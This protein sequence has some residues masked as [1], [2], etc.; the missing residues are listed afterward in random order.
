MS[1]HQAI[2]QA[3]AASVFEPI[4]EIA[5]QNGFTVNRSDTRMVDDAPL[6]LVVLEQRG[7]QTTVAFD[8][9]SKAELQMLKELYA[10]R[11]AKLGFAD[12]IIW[13][14]PKAAAPLNQ[15]V[16]EIS[17]CTQI[18]PNFARVRLAGD[19]TAFATKTAGLHFRFLFGPEGTAWPTLDANGLTYW[20]DG[21][22]SWHRPPYTVRRLAP[23][24]SWIDVDI[25]L[26]DGGR[27]TEWCK[28]VKPGDEIALTGPS[29]SKMPTENKLALFG[30]E[31]ALPIIFRIVED[32]PPDVSGYATIAVRNLKDSQS[33]SAS[34][35]FDIR[36]IDMT[37]PDALVRGLHKSLHT[38]PDHSVFFAAERTQA[39]T[40]RKLLK[41]AE[42]ASRNDR[43]ASYWTKAP[44]VTKAS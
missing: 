13:S 16:C 9:P 6:G 20:P 18:S 44:K 19:F 34:P 39:D 10:Q 25:V 40:V 11:F 26:H 29:G 7:D 30:D 27:V 2:L 24:A 12:G 3:D 15:V 4:K 8:A 17:D 22:S 28:R 5:E 23:D 21:V 37:D 38:R 31:T 43:V 42:R 14:A 36:W 33:I 32:A 1:K 35:Q 41:D